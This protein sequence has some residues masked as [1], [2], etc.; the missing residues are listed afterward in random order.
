MT[1]GDWVSSRAADAPATLVDGVREAL[2]SEAGHASDRAPAV[3]LDATLRELKA[4]L[5]TGGASRSA[6]VP[7]LTIDALATL[8]MEAAAEEPG[9]LDEFANRAI[10]RIAKVKP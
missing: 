3:L 8:A 2:G 10:Q 4:W 5:T 1:V 7:L 9:V 6:A